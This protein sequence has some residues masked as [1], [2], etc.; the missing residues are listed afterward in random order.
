MA[1]ASSNLKMEVKHAVDVLK[2]GGVVI[3]PT[4]TSYGISCDATNVKAVR[5]VFAIKGRPEGKGTPLIVDSFLMAKKWG[6]FNLMAS[7]LA[8]HYWPGALTIVVPAKGKVA[9]MV[10]QDK[11][12]ALR[13]SSNETA[14]ALAKGLGRP[15]VATSAN[16]AGEPP[17]Y[18]LRAMKRLLNQK[19]ASDVYVL[20]VGALPRRKPTTLVKT[21]DDAFVI[22]RQGAI[23]L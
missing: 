12:V 18:S 4:E 2:R 22:L 16:L 13:V 14:R 19:I 1:K 11:T 3:F 7:V 17:S 15:V 8:K 10:L 20:N 21:T 9:G 23:K 5:R 6:V